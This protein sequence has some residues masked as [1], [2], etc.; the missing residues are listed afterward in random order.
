MI[1]AAHKR[2]SEI[3]NS[4]PDID[5]EG[6]YHAAVQ[7][8]QQQPTPQAP[9]KL[10]S[11]AAAL[12][13]PQNAPGMLSQAT[14]MQHAAQDQKFQRIQSLKEA[15]IHGDIQQAMAKGDFKRALAQSEELEKLHAHQERLAREQNFTMFKNQQ[16]VLQGNRVELDNL[17]NDAA[18]ARAKA[19]IAGRADLKAMSVKQQD[20]YAH[21]YS[22]TYRTIKSQK[23]VDGTPT[24]TDEQ[25]QEMARQSTDKSFAQGERAPGSPG[26]VGGTGEVAT[27]P[28]AGSAQETPLARQIRL[29]REAQKK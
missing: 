12:G 2:L 22:T 21:E 16:D 20:M 6:K 26:R 13:S 8:A 28:P 10:Q 17:R 1:S 5:Y 11:F 9:G 27:T 3:L 14:Q 23:N 25:A 19:I 7:A 18:M 29:N 15:I 24:Y 4:V